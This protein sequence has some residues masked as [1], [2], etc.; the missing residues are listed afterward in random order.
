MA[1]ITFCGLGLMGLPMAGRLLDAGHDLTVWNRSPAKARDLESRGATVAE[2]P[3]AAASNAEVVITMLATPEAVEEVL[4]SDEGVA[5]GISRGA[6]M[7]EM[8]TI[9]P[10]ALAR[11]ARSLPDGV[12]LLDAPVLGSVPQATNGQ[13]KIFV[14]GDK[15]T[16]ERWRDVLEVLGT[17]LY[18]GRTGAGAAMKVVANSTLLALMTALGEA[19]ALADSLGLEEGKV[20]DILEESPIGAT[21][22]SK[23]KNIET[24]TYPPNFKL[25]LVAK[26]GRLVDDAASSGDVELRVAAAARAWAEE[27]DRLGLGDLDYS[28]VVAHIRG[29]K[30]TKE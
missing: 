25:E 23:R 4:L 3:S 22:K 12:E 7:I 9:G 11:V 6:V 16:F 18:L 10:S 27:A 20:L 30:A 17:P 21:V 29:Q 8:S 24:G 1:R 5:H 14:G 13:L 26:D 15:D 28:A 2:S 19:L